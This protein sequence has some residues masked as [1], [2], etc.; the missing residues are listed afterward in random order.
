MFIVEIEELLRNAMGL[1]AA[2]LGR[3][4]VRQ[5][6]RI[7]LEQ[8]GFQDGID[9]LEHVRQSPEELQ[10]LIEAVVVPETWFFRHVEAFQAFADWVQTEWMS[11]QR[12]RMLRILS[13]P[14]STGEEPYSIAMALLDSGFPAAQFRLDAIDISR[15]SLA[16]AS[17]AVYRDNSFRSTD[18][19]F[20]DRYFSREGGAF[21]L[22]AP[23]RKLVHFR[24]GN[25]LAAD[26]N[27]GGD[28]YDVIFCR[29]VLI[30]FDAEKQ[31]ETVSVLG[32][33]LDPAGVF[34]VGPAEGC[35]MIDAGFA[36]MKQRMSFGF[37]KR[38]S[39]PASAAPHKAEAPKRKHRVI[40]VSQPVPKPVLKPMTKPSS[41]AGATRGNIATVPDLA[42]ARELA[43]AGQLSDA[44]DACE[45]LLRTF[46][47]SAEVYALLGIVQ[48]AMGRIH[49]A[50]ESYRRAIYL[51]PG[52]HQ[53]LAHLAVI[54][55]RKHDPATARRLR[56]RARRAEKRLMSTVQAKE[57]DRW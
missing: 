54:A 3:E 38:S 16:H 51:D 14:C 17:H 33:L 25:L 29:N 36:P 6:V 44:H 30:Y 56:E 52:H 19:T 15:T 23:V 31:K 41:T 2:S 47:N 18:L 22:A 8:C 35:L 10:L 26:F 53:A 50:E 43:D 5:A 7:R 57:D 9:Y 1:D 34:F 48:D 20:R 49:E 28:A 46:G 24:Q 37:R 42:K 4:A 12:A 55:D 45:S 40:P 21:R 11:A 13:V 39:P 32:R 27:I